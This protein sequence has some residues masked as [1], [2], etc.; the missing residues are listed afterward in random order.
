MAHAPVPQAPVAQAA[1]AQAAAKS[2]VGKWIVL[3]ITMLL[4]LGGSGVVVA[5]MGSGS[6]IEVINL[7]PGEQLYVSGVQTDARNVRMDGSSTYVIS[8][9]MNGR[10]RRFGTT[11]RKDT[12]D[13]RTLPEAMPQP[14]SNGTVTIGGKTGCYVKVGS[15]MLSGSTPVKANVPAGQ[16]LE[17]T[18]S[19]PGQPVWVQ[20][21]MAVPGQDLDLTPTP[22]Q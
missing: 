21:V 18:V 2:S 9:A 4:L 10:L 13:V 3:S 17:L 15:E 8:T 5:K 22:G 20:K 1:M 16:E 11:M 7:E 6:D 19:C 14:G 12:I